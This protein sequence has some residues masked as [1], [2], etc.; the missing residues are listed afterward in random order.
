MANLCLGIYTDTG[1]K[2]IK[3]SKGML[4]TNLKSD[5]LSRGGQEEHIIR[6]R[7]RKGLPKDE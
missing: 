5:N 4:N 6:E 7:P 1:G 2:T 3:K